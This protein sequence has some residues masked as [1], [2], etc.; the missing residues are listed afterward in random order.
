MRRCLAVAG[1]IGLWNTV[2]LLAQAPPAPKDSLLRHLVGRWTMRGSVRGR[3]ATYRL[4]VAWTLQRRFVELHMVDVHSPPAYE[5]RVFV[6]SDTVPGQYLAHW[7]DNFGA[8]YS[9]PPAT[10]RARGDTLILHFP[11]PTGTFQDT[12]VYDRATNAWN[13]RLDV[14]DGSGGWKLFAEYRAT[15][16]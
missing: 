2:P 11:Y 14:A 3:P 10:G 6:G 15:R 13:M 8:A 7:M 12:F 9:V 5:A 1:L 16:R 4:D